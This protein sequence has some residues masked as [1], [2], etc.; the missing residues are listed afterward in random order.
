M[1]ENLREEL[2][3]Y[4]KEN[5]RMQ[6]KLE[7]KGSNSAYN[8]ISSTSSA[9]LNDIQRQNEALTQEIEGLRSKLKQFA[10]TQELASMLQESHK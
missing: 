3:A 6:L 7:H 5:A 4:V 1:Q 10:Q 2:Q 8:N 9:N